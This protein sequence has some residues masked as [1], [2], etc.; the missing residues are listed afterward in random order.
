MIRDRVSRLSTAV[1]G[2]SALGP[3]LLMGVITLGMASILQG[4]LARFEPMG[5]TAGAYLP[6]EERPHPAFP[7]TLDLRR[8]PGI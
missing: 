1:V 8:A 7:M 2:R 5:H 6:P 3:D 4:R